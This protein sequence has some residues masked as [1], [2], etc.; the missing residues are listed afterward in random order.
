MKATV[1]ITI[2]IGAQLQCDIFKGILLRFPLFWEA[3]I[4][5]EYVLYSR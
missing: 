4:I 5:P 3:L 1:G 2:A